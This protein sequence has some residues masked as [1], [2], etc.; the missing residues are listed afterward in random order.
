MRRHPR[1]A[2]ASTV[3]AVG[4][5]II[6]ALGIAAWSRGARLAVD[7][8]H[9]T[10][11]RVD[12]DLDAARTVLNSPFST[13]G[14]STRLWSAADFV[15]TT[16]RHR[17]VGARAAVRLSPAARCRSPAVAQPCGRV[18]YLLAEWHSPAGRAVAGVAAARTVVG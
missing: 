7:R 4:A 5:V 13:I 3:A 14:N 16:G 18:V 1:L 9:E 10:L 8:A 12:A 15:D 11:R 6:V 17:R 2:S